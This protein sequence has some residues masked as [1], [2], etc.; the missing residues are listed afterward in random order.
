MRDGV[1]GLGA[2]PLGALPRHE[3]VALVRAALD[4]GIT[5]LDTAPSY[6][7]SEE[8]LG[9]ALRGDRA[10][11]TLVT[12]G[13]Y[14]VP[15]AADWSAEVITRGI[16][17]A[18]RVLRTDYLDAF[19]LHSCDEAKLLDGELL[20]P[21]TRAKR[22]GKVRAIGYSGDGDAL[23]VAAWTPEFDVLECS[24]NVLDR[25]ALR[26]IRGRGKRVLAKRVLANAPWS[27]SAD[28]TRP[29]VAEYMR[30]YAALA[31]SG[32]GIPD[33]ELFARFAAFA[34]G[35]DVALVGTTR[36]ANLDAVLAAVEKGPLPADVL[37]ALDAK[38]SAQRPA[39]G[40]L[41]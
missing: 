3:G 17:R 11:I 19:L 12:K 9:D 34:P 5:L 7:A 28:R 18:L 2:G 37:A 25:E 23:A 27:P 40:G 4:R 33:V 20:E 31:P 38:W 13:G 36:I 24:V 30:R 29:D 22:A 35:V 15:G 16:E 21:L 10:R 26:T 41:V 1:I 39:W 8:I 6:G 14:G 32:A